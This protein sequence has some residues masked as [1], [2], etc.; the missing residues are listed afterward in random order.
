[1]ASRAEVMGELKVKSGEAAPWNLHC[2]EEI[3]DSGCGITKSLDRNKGLNS[4]VQLN[5]LLL[6]V[7]RQ[8]N[9]SIAMRFALVCCLQCKDHAAKI[10]CLKL[11]HVIEIWYGIQFIAIAIAAPRRATIFFKPL[12]IF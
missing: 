5:G 3:G 8:K 7:F 2:P 9:H 4:S 11:I 6:P 1:M 10:R 12:Y